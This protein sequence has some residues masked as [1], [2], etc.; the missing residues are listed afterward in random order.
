MVSR[1]GWWYLVGHDRGRDASRVFRLS[2]VVGAVE[3]VGPAGAVSR[4]DDVDLTDAVARVA[5]PED[6][7]TARVRVRVGTSAGLR[8]NVRTTVR[9]DDDWEELELGY[10]DADRLAGRVAQYG[11]DAVVVAPDE[12]RDAVV[13]HLTGELEGAVR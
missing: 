13:R 1:R 3:V 5:P 2:R 7:H 9:V 12:V 8:R 6:T 10:A 4:P 11:P